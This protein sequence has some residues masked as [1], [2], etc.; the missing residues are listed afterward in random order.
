MLLWDG[1]SMLVAGVAFLVIVKSA[2]YV[3][4][5]L[6]E[7]LPLGSSSQLLAW[8]GTGDDTAVARE[9]NNFSIATTFRH[10]KAL[11]GPSAV[12]ILGPLARV[13]IG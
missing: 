12:A 10:G 9:V 11:Q 1:Q 5:V 7:L 2:V 4:N 3:T 6:V 13:E 8:I